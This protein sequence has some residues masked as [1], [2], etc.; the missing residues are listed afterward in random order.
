MCSY[1]IKDFYVIEHSGSELPEYVALKCRNGGSESPDRWLKSSRRN[2]VDCNKILCT[3]I[4]IKN[5]IDDGQIEN[6]IK[7]SVKMTKYSLG[8]RG[9]YV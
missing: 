4:E 8:I 2:Q 7:N 5:I 1:S 9:K 6:G 3:P